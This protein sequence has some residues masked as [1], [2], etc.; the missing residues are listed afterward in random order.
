MLQLAALAVGQV[1]EPFGV[2]RI[3]TVQ[4]GP[5]HLPDRPGSTGAITGFSSCRD[6]RT[7]LRIAAPPAFDHPSARLFPVPRPGAGAEIG[8]EQAAPF[9]GIARIVRPIRRLGRAPF[10]ERGLV[11]GTLDAGHQ[12]VERFGKPPLLAGRLEQQSAEDDLAAGVALPLLLAARASSCCSR[13]WACASR[14]RVASA[15]AAWGA[16]MRIGLLTNGHAPCGDI[17]HRLPWK[18]V[19]GRT[20]ALLSQCK[21]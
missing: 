4:C 13:F 21:R 8:P 11:L 1:S 9:R 5:F 2:H 17:R 3:L 6:Q 10:G 15:E 14:V 12:L 16:G 18:G 7:P 20:L 19:E